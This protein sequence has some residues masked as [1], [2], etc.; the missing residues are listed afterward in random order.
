M[1]NRL[2]A[3][4]AL[5]AG[6]LFSIAPAMAQSN[7]RTPEWARGILANDAEAMRVN[8]PNLVAPEGGVAVR[9]TIAPAQGGVARLVRYNS[10]AERGDIGLRR[11]TGHLR[12]GW[13]LWGG[14]DPVTTTPAPA[15][16]AQLDRLARTA[17]SAGL[18]G[19]EGNDLGAATCVDGD[20][21][22][23][24]VADS[25]RAVTFERR[26]ATSG[27][28]G[29][30]IKALSDAAGSRDEEELYQSGLAEIVGADNAFSKTARDQGV[31]A[32]MATFAAEDGR[33]FL[34]RAPMI[35][36]RE[37][38]ERQYASW[39]AQ[40]LLQWEPAGADISARGD[41][42]FSWGRWTLTR[43]GAEPASGNYVSV[44]R[45]DGEG[46]WRFLANIGN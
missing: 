26:C 45:R 29:A 40:S 11:F 30:L 23:L 9:L 17:L 33:V 13:T 28:A 18:M 4:F 37:N 5:M 34:S 39:D 27:A 38:I 2:F 31:P 25:A 43:E 20:Y 3:A 10:G 15:L 22:W 16:K 14:E 42:G 1:H 32:A 7:A 44:W 6:A 8:R 36:G 41:M 35:A 46:E 24:E 12:N 19:G 21:A